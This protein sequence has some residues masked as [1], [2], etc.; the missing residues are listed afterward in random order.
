MFQNLFVMKNS[1]ARWSFL[2]VVLAACAAP[3]F[4]DGV[5][6][7]SVTEIALDVRPGAREP[8]L[9]VMS[10]GRVAMSWT[11]PAGADF[12]V[13]VA[14][15]DETGVEAPVPVFRSDRLMVN[16]A[17]FPSV[18]AFPD[19]TLAVHW[20]TESA[21]SFYAYDIN[22]ALSDDQGLSWSDPVVPY[23][24]TTP[25]QHGFVSMLPLAKDRMLVT[26]LDG[27]TYQSDTGGDPKTTETDDMQLRMTVIDPD[28][29]T[30]GD[31]LLDASTCS[32]C[33]TSATETGD[34]TVVIAYRDRTPAEI[35]DISVV[36]NVKGAWT[37]PMIVH[38]DGWEISGCPVNGPAIDAKG[39][40]VAVAWFTA[41]SGMP[42]VNVAFSDNAA[43]SF[44]AP[45]RLDTGDAAGR[46]DVLQLQDG[47][48]LVTW[49]EW[50]VAGEALMVCRVTPDDGC[51]ARQRI[52]WN[53]AP[54]SMNF[55]RMVE[56]P[57][58]VYI[59]W[60]Q[61]LSPPFPG[62]EKD[63]TVR[64]VLARF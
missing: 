63:T 47:S 30:T 51:Q 10:D 12:A 25:A 20:L 2:A 45:R 31:D 64:L 44:G 19:G 5:V 39:Q 26:W 33:Q 59:A 36:R 28:G 52:V 49:V 22:I 37:K 15:F 11:E 46:V 40:N 24:D 60:T 6:F 54:G 42:R 43:E 50:P 1:S 21:Q 16:W 56:G 7:S 18:A 17:D 62:P 4:S 38:A 14:T 57:G 35:R 61:P 34:G 23:Q 13:N 53:D 41:A 29:N 27:R 58:G 48:T 3:A 32:C 9:A 55:P 8:D